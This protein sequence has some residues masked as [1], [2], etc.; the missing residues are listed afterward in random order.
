LEVYLIQ[1]A[2]AKPKEADP[3]QPLTDDGRCAIEKVAEHVSRLGIAFGEIYHSGKLWS[4]QTASF[5]ADHLGVKEIRKRDGIAPLDDVKCTMGW[6]REKESQGTRSITIVGHLP[7]L[8]KLISL[9]VVGN[10]S[11]EVVSFH[12]GGI[13]KLAAKSSGR[14]FA[15]DW[16]LAPELLM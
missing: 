8:D 2:E 15:I 10:K 9:L 7:F 1:H 4:L 16:I 5:L 14:G 3:E 11:T 12:R 6:L 13:V